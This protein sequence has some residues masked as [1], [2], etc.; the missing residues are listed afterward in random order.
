MTPENAAKTRHV[1]ADLT[2]ENTALPAE[3][4]DHLEHSP[5]TGHTLRA[6]LGAVCSRARSTATH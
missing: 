1:Q 5:L 2:H 4:A 6:Y 3:C